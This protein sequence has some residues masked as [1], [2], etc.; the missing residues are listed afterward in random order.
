MPHTL[1][2]PLAYPLLNARSSI[3]Q[4]ILPIHVAQHRQNVERQRRQS[5][6]Q[7]GTELQDFQRPSNSRSEDQ[8]G[9]QIHN[10]AD[11]FSETEAAENDSL[12]SEPDQVDTQMQRKNRK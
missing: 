10:E 5:L 6:A 4:P 9:E 12:L 11:S 1:S 2:E 3:E 7:E 8:I